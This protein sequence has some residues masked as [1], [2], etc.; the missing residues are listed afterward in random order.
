[1]ERNEQ[2]QYYRLGTN[3]WWLVGK[4]R[5]VMDQISRHVGGQGGL[6][7]LDVGCGPGNTLDRLSAYGQ[8]VGMD[9][10]G[11]A[12]EY[13]RSR[14]YRRVF[15]G[16]APALP[17]A[18]ETFDLIV[19]IDVIEHVEDDAAAVGEAFR[20]L[21]SGGLYVLTVPAFMIL[22]GD[23]DELYFHHRRYRVPQIRKLVQGSGFRIEKLSY[24]EPA[25][26]LPML[27]FRR[28]KRLLGPGHRKDDFIWVPGWLNAILGSMIGAERYWLRWLDFPFGVTSI[29]VCRKPG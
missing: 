2:E 19:S 6:R 4:Y 22:W 28:L 23:H 21:K 15:V 14:G 16:A 12:V 3:Y 9:Y 1:M 17:V 25:F 24:F 8:G 29:C 11:D 7:I 26:F 10:S 27:V 5:I 13:C 18:E 20:A